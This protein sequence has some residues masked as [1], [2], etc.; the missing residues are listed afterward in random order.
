MS[1]DGAV[2]VEGDMGN[3]GNETAQN[4]YE[5]RSAIQVSHWYTRGTIVNVAGVFFSLAG[6]ALAEILD[7]TWFAVVGIGIM[8]ALLP[9]YVVCRWRAGVWEQELI[10]V[11]F[12]PM[13]RH[14]PVPPAVWQFVV[15]GIGALL[16][17]VI[18][19]P[20][21]ESSWA[22]KMTF[23]GPLIF[24]VLAALAYLRRPPNI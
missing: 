18:L 8:I 14:R 10:S 16:A 12:K 7:E 1:E 23:L 4:V 24:S 15:L 3:P 20:H 9:L 22:L 19:L 5:R 6:I 17:G 13:I 11:G 2:A 21:W